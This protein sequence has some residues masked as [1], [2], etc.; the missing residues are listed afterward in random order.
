MSM[1]TM[2]RTTAIGLLCNGAQH[3]VKDSFVLGVRPTMAAE[4]ELDGCAEDTDGWPLK[5]ARHGR[6][7]TLDTRFPQSSNADGSLPTS[8]DSQ[9]TLPDFR[10]DLDAETRELLG[11]FYRTYT[12]L[13]HRRTKLSALPTLTRVVGDVICKHRIA[14][15]GMVQ[16]LQ[17][18]EQS[19][20]LEVVSTVAKSMFSDG[21]TN[22]GRVASLVAFGAVLCESLKESG[23]DHCVDTVAHRI[24]S[25]LTTYQ[26]EWLLNNKS[27][28]GFKE[29]FQ[30][31]DPESVV[32][33]ALMAV[34]GFA[35][36]GAG[37]ALLMR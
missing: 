21:M 5:P 30:V 6:G 33:N 8:P 25:Y 4:D 31:E 22:W 18:E 26:H 20:D 19:D 3:G 17:M 23:R 14:Y 16:K 27:W 37:L 32:R 2:K 34:A 13:P 9:E 7:L 11:Y 29:F 24:S 12:G 35:G 28:D 10:S 36:L 15:N 1:T